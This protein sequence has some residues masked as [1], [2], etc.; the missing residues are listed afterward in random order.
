MLANLF[1][2]IEFNV[3]VYCI[4]KTSSAELVYEAD[5]IENL[6][7]R[8]IL[9][10]PTTRERFIVFRNALLFLQKL[11]RSDDELLPRLSSKIVRVTLVPQLNV[12]YNF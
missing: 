7:D 12:N 3:M 11:D 5:Y 1:N 10:N 8:Q 6:L 4:S 9:A 2:S